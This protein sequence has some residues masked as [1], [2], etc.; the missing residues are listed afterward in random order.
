MNSRGILYFMTAKEKHRKHAEHIVSIHGG[1]LKRSLKTLRHHMKGVPAVLFT[2]F[3]SIDWKPYGFD[4]I[5][6][7]DN[8]GDIWEYKYDCLLDTPFERTIHMD[9]DTYICDNFS[10]VFK[11]MDGVDFAVPLSPW[12]LNFSRVFKHIPVS[13]PEPAGGFMAYKAND[14]VFDMFRYAKELISDRIG[15]CDEPYLRIAM[16]EKDVKFSILPWEYNCVFLLPGFLLRKPKVLHGKV[17]R[18]KPI[19]KVMNANNLPKIYTGEKLIYC[20]KVGR[21]TYTM[22]RVEKCGHEFGG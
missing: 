19:A 5:I 8:P 15:G 1:L 13:F 17:D 21:K 18:I 9:C 22:G 20:K 3:D 14:K 11:M 7:K 12:Y 4:K 16:Y 6:Y 10:E 2:S